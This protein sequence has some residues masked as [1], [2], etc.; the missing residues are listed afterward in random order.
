MRIFVIP[1]IHGMLGELQYIY[2]FLSEKLLEDDT[3]LLFLG[4]YIHGGEDSKGVI[5]FVIRLQEQYGRDKIIAL[6]GNH[7][8]FVMKGYSS[9]EEMQLSSEEVEDRYLYWIESLPRF[10]QEGNTIFC[11]AGID[12]TLQADWD[13]TDDYTFTNKY[14]HELGKIEGLD[15]KV[16]SGHIHT[17]EI[18]EDSSFDGIYYDGYSH[19]YLDGDVLR[20]GKLNILLVETGEYED[21]YFEVIENRV[22]PIIEYFN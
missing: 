21:K 14:P 16:V 3:K 8:E 17:S 20:T 6:L 1:D 18:A 15:F 9:I 5:D 12:E 19:I 4:D 11:H 13:Y 10:Y 22:Y 2:S 7:E